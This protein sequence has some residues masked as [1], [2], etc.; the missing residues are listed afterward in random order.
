MATRIS[1]YAPIALA[2]CFSPQPNAGL[3]C[4]PAGS[5]PRCP[6]GLV[7]VDSGGGETCELDAVAGGDAATADARPPDAI[8]VDGSPTLDSDGDGVVDAIDNCPQQ[9]NPPQYDE[10]GDNLGDLCDPCP[11][12][13]D[14]ADPDGDEVGGPCDPDPSTPGNAIAA[15]ADFNEMPAGWTAVGGVTFDSGDAMFVSGATE[16]VLH[17]PMPNAA[18]VVIAARATPTAFG[19]MLGGVGVVQQRHPS[20][21]DA[22]ACQLVNAPSALRIYDLST[23]TTVS[24]AAHPVVVDQSYLLVSARDGIT[25][26]CYAS[27][28][29]TELVDDATY[30]PASPRI[31]VRVRNASARFHWAIVLTRP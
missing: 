6:S 21:D 23:A 31:G 5:E 25:Y 16:V 2:A 17:T 7:C 20:T 27:D 24:E 22:I 15:F 19:A 1:R 14:N 29:D 13:V 18:R 26:S 11:V 3:P 4:A 28:P 30:A 10:D 12:D 9:P 8:P